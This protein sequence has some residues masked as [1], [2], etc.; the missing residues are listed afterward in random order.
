M[1]KRGSIHQTANRGA[2]RSKVAF[3][4]SAVLCPAR[5][6]NARVQS[7]TTREVKQYAQGLD[8]VGVIA[9]SLSNWGI[10]KRFL[11]TIPQ[12]GSVYRVHSVFDNLMDLLLKYGQ[13]LPDRPPMMLS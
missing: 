2:S 8:A 5:G 13:S 3:S 11:E 1:P 12:E 10:S 4:L 7:W 9:T 6:W